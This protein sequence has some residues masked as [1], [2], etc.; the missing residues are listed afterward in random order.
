MT[1]GLPSSRRL[2]MVASE[3]RYYCYYKEFIVRAGPTL[4]GPHFGPKN[5]VH[6]TRTNSVWVL[7]KM[8]YIWPE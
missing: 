3:E 6:C 5:G 7:T 1:D 8:N 2:P 4:A